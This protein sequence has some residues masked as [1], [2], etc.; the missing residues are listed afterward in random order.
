MHDLILIFISYG[1]GVA[2]SVFLFR[3]L[4]SF[5]EGYEAAKKFYTDWDKG[6]DDGFNHAFVAME[7]IAHTWNEQ[8]ERKES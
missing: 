1:L 8:A 2:V 3:P 4:K 6:F 7:E 5:N